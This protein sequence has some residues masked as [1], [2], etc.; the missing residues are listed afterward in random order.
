MIPDD[1]HALYDRGVQVARSAERPPPPGGTCSP[2][3]YRIWSLRRMKLPGFP[4][5]SSADS[6]RVG[7]LRQVLRIRVTLCGSSSKTDVPSGTSQK[8][9]QRLCRCVRLVAPG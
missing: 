8:R 7:C 3:T 9:T 6:P 2:L 4:T 1:Y 5:G